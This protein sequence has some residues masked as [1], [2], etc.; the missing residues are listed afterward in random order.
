MWLVTALLLLAGCAKTCIGIGELGSK[1]R[2]YVIAV[3]EWPH[4]VDSS[5]TFAQVQDCFES[6]VGV[7]VTFEIVA[8]ARSVARQLHEFNANLGVMDA[9]EF[10]SADPAQRL[11]AYLIPLGSDAFYAQTVLLIKNSESVLARRDMNA[12]L[13]GESDPY[14]LRLAD[15]GRVA[16]HSQA[17]VEGFLVPRHLLL[18]A[19]VFPERSVFTGDW[20]LSLQLLQ[21]GEA[22]LAALSADYLRE[23]WKV[24]ELSVGL[25]RQGVFVAALSPEFPRRVLVTQKGAS[26]RILKRVREG[27]QACVAGGLKDQIRFIFS[28]ERFASAQKES[29]S[30]LERIVMFQKTFLRVLPS[31]NELNQ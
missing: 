10:V 18:E 4:Q 28:G 25:S 17:S 21:K 5:A 2:P 8:D 7:R 24:S 20:G 11:S 31:L 30:F 9:N 3:A 16:Y 29:F 14:A 1:E 12:H 26:K 27:L 19:G 15:G 6:E 23:A 22:D 13:I